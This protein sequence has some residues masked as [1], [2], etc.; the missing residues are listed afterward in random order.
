MVRADRRVNEY[1]ADQ[2]RQNVE[3]APAPAAS[4]AS[5][6]ALVHGPVARA[7]EEAGRRQARAGLRAQAPPGRSA[8]D[9][10]RQH[11]GCRAG[12]AR[13]EHRGRRRGDVPPSGIWGQ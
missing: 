4:S 8:G 11:V 1:L 2:A 12:R 6:G 3:R 10:G 7:P 5:G 13:A 9:G